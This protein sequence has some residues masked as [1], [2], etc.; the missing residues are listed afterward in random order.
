MSSEDKKEIVKAKFY[1]YSDDV[2]MEIHSISKEELDKILEENQD[3]MKELEE[4]DYA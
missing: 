4:R 1:E 2:I 3:Y